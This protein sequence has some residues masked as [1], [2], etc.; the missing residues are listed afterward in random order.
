MYYNWKEI[1]KEKSVSELISIIRQNSFL[2]DEAQFYAKQELLNR[3]I[4]LTINDEEN[5]NLKYELGKEELIRLNK[6][7][8]NEEF[9]SMYNRKHQI[10]SIVFSNILIFLWIFFQFDFDFLKNIKKEFD[11]FSNI[12]IF[13]II[14]SGL[15]LSIWRL[16]SIDK[17]NNKREKRIAELK[18]L[19]NNFK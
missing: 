13:I 16:K 4:D 12:T 15:L 10:Y 8:K 3:K 7:I 19:I 1:F 11:G 14:L 17:T 9:N 18:K 5:Q 6:E 2:N